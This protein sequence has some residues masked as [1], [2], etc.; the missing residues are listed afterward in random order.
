MIKLLI[1]LIRI[2]FICK[3]NFLILIPNFFFL[4]VIFFIFNFSFRGFYW[5]RIYY[6]LGIDYLS[7][8]LIILVIWI[9]GLSILARKNFLINSFGQ[10]FYLLILLLVITLIFV[11]FS[12]NIFIFYVFF[13][14]RLIPMVIIII[15]WGYQVDRIQASIYL[16]IYTIFG[17]LP[18]LLILSYFYIELNRIY[19]TILFYN[20]YYDFGSLFF[21]LII[22]LGGLVKIPL[23]FIHIWLPKAHVEAPVSGSIILAGIILKLGRYII[24]RFINIFNVSINFTHILV[25]VGIIGSVYCRI[26]C[27]TQV[28]LKVIVAY[29]S[30]VHINILLVGLV[31][32]GEWG[33]LGRVLIIF[34]HGLNS[35]IL[36]YLV[37]IIYE[38]LHSR[39]LLIIK[40]LINLF[41]SLSLWWLLGCFS[42]FSVPPSLSLFGEIFLI[43]I[44]I[45][46]SKILLIII[47]IVFFFRACYSIYIYIYRNHG[48]RVKLIRLRIITIC[49]Y[50]I[51]ILHWVPLNLIFIVLL[52]F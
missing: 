32:I 9:C 48:V 50:L 15:G 47:V 16:L 20:N 13:E 1:L 45:R 31:R 27:L 49:E 40:G 25:R 5:G 42:N 33:N 4:I 51:L 19:F 39:R 44:I 34:S 52:I 2:L 21:Y 35:S 46:Y 14:A 7:I 43:I 11:F 17:S 10:I 12:T 23:Y 6:L 18:L 24:Y 3:N 29:S 37:N 41:P 8:I 22:M 38:R 28:D 30:V 26:I 36:F